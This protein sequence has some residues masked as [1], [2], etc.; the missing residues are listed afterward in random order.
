MTPGELRSI[1]SKGFAI[2]A[3]T[4]THPILRLCDPATAKDEI[5][6]AREELESIVRDRVTLFAYPNGHP[7]A[8]FA[9]LHVKL[10][11]Q[12]GYLGAVTTQPG[13]AGFG[14]PIFQIPRFTPWGPDRLRMELQI[15]RNVLSTPTY[16]SA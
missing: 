10:V 14:S 6:G 3:H 7:V 13:A 1:H 9:E 2:G 15:I 16:L 12:A 5:G 8:D 11:R 4:M